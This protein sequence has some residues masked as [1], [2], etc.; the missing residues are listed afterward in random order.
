MKTFTLS[1]NYLKNNF[2]VDEK[3]FREN[4]D[5]FSRKD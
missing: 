3:V 1:F 4:V 5:I 2:E